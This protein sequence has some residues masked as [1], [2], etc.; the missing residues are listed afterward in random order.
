MRR[1][2]FEYEDDEE[3]EDGDGDVDIEN[4]YYLA[5]QVKGDQP[6]D[7]IAEFLGVAELEP[8]KGEW[9][10]IHADEL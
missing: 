10:V 3:E 7:A 2:A 1:F 9:C 5:K 4:R 6:K 8:E